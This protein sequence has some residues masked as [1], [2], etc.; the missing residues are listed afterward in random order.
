M[1]SDKIDCRR[2]IRAK[3]CRIG[4]AACE[5]ETKF[6]IVLTG[7]HELMRMCLDARGDTNQRFRNC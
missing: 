7:A 5:A 1:E 6:G 4:L 2:S 3:N